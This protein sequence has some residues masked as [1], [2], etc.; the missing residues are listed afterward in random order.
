MKYYAILCSNSITWSFISS[1]FALF[2]NLLCKV[3]MNAFFLFHRVLHFIMWFQSSHCLYCGY[4]VDVNPLFIIM[5]WIPWCVNFVMHFNMDRV[6]P[7]KKQFLASILM[8]F[9]ILLT[10][11]WIYIFF[12]YAL[13][14]WFWL[15]SLLLNL[16]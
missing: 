6:A 14:W 2:I 16:I 13:Y 12:C 4:S 10:Y 8:Y 15:F 1:P 7:S 11:E 9:T 3:V 5:L